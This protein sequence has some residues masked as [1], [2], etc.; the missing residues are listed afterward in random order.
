[1]EIF[2]VISSLP[3]SLKCSLLVAL[4]LAYCSINDILWDGYSIF[5][6]LLCMPIVVAEVT[7]RRNR[8]R[9]FQEPETVLDVI[10]VLLVTLLALVVL[11]ALS[12]DLIRDNAVSRV[13]IVKDFLTPD[14]CAHIVDIAE[15]HAAVHGWQTTRHKSYPTTDFSA[16]AVRQNISRRVMAG[17]PSLEAL[18]RCSTIDNRTDSTCSSSGSTSGSSSTSGSTICEGKLPLSEEVDFGTWLNF[19]VA[20]RIFPLLRAQYGLGEGVLSMKDLFLVKYDGDT[21]GAQRH[22][23]LHTDSS[24][25]SFNIALSAP[26]R[27]RDPSANC[28]PK[29]S[30]P[31]SSAAI[32]GNTANS[33]G[34]G[35]GGDT[36]NSSGSGSGVDTANSSGS[37]SGG[38]SA[39]SSGSGS[40][41]GGDSSTT[42]PFG[43]AVELEQ[44]IEGTASLPQTS[45]MSSGIS[46]ESSGYSDSIG[47]ANDETMSSSNSSRIGNDNSSS[48]VAG[49]RWT[50]F[51]G[52][53]THFSL[54]GDGVVLP[55]GQL[56]SHPSGLFHAGRG[57]QAGQRYIVVGFVRVR[58]Y[59]WGTIWRRFGAFSKCL[60]FM[61]VTSML[62]DYQDNGDGDGDDHGHH[63]DGHDDAAAGDSCPI[64]LP[65]AVSN[66]GHVYDSRL[67]VD[68][69]YQAGKPTS[70]SPYLLLILSR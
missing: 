62:G 10:L 6:V 21:R 40:G 9:S 34:S 25:L 1:M 59:T 41:G 46:H 4:T 17:D 32:A 52:G 57:V 36:A 58:R 67:D 3:V 60:Q 45:P 54:T 13:H 33:S 69:S 14:Q 50:C 65:Y 43:R 2:S 23:S 63:G 35:S 15:R 11:A 44:S 31:A 12:L 18:L 5:T 16:F 39:N 51:R 30:T 29:P 48:T 53:G 22:L 20:H 49:Q 19:T 24:Q 27:E 7:W 38:D 26:S 70:L 61:R 42:N 66:R 37:G 28:Q 47:D 68:F 64:V 55:Q 56:L 8:H